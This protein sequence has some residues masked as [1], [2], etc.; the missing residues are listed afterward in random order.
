[1]TDNEREFSRLDGSSHRKLVV[2]IF[3]GTDRGQGLTL[4]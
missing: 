4:R 1:V 2:M 3:D